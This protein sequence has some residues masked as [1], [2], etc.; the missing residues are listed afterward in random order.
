MDIHLLNSSIVK[1][2]RF[3]YS[4]MKVY[5][6]HA[7]TDE[8]L[9]TSCYMYLAILNLLSIDDLQEQLEKEQQCSGRSIVVLITSKSNYRNA[10]YLSL[11]L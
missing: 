5:R 7:T 10:S 3:F 11:N 1:L 2:L 4:A 9:M 8:R 6:V